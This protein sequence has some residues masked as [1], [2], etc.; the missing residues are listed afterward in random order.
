MERVL[1]KIVAASRRELALRKTA[2]PAAELE[3]K[4]DGLPPVRDF[5]AALTAPG[6]QVI[7][8]LKAASPSKGIIRQPLEVEALA[9]ELERSGAAA[10]SVLTE[11]NYFLGGLENLERARKV[12]ELPL[13]RKDFIY[14]EYQILEAR[15]A[16][17][18]A[19]LLIAAMLAPAEYRRLQ[20][21]AESLGLA[22][23]SEAHTVGVNARNLSTFATDL[24]VVAELM[25]RI[26]ADK[27]RVSESAL[28]SAADLKQMKRLGADAFL[29]GETLMR[30]ASPGEKLCE[31]IAK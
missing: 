22:V 18:D 14:D 15:A 24:G 16:G 13:L 11:R 12:V 2:V 1:E 30:A 27:V 29:I 25:G 4:L 26:P 31:L 17:A 23:L 7:A 20:K 3:R 28:K 5:R 9:V 10:L 19:V 6:M 21:F 8:E